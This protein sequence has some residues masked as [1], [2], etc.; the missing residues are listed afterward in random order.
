[1]TTQKQLEEQ[2]ATRTD[3]EGVAET[4]GLV[5]Q[6]NQLKAKLALAEEMVGALE[7]TEAALQKWKDMQDD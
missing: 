5:N 2:G 6:I 3:F 1:M 4:L 7:A